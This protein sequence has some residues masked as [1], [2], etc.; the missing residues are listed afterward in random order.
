MGPPPHEIGRPG[1]IYVDNSSE[2]LAIYGRDKVRWVIWPGPG[3][4]FRHP[5]LEDRYLWCSEDRIAWYSGKFVVDDAKTRSGQTTVEMI[6]QALTNEFE[7]HGVSDTEE[8]RENRRQRTKAEKVRDEASQSGKR[9]SSDRKASDD[10]ERLK[11]QKVE[12]NGGH[13]VEETSCRHVEGEGEMETHGSDTSECPSEGTDDEVRQR[14]LEKEA[15]IVN[16][17]RAWW[18]DAVAQMCGRCPLVEARAST[19]DNE[20]RLLEAT[21]RVLEERCAKEER[22]RRRLAE[23]CDN[24]A[25]RRDGDNEKVAADNQSLECLHQTSREEVETLGQNI[26]ALKRKVSDD[27]KQHLDLQEKNMRQ[28]QQIALLLGENEKM[29]SGQE[30][31]SRNAEMSV[32]PVTQTSKMPKIVLDCLPGHMGQTLATHLDS[33]ESYNDK[34]F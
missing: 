15:A 13:N 14:N 31:A 17:Q 11:R 8:E 23:L 25:E 7:G 9:T 28:E 30:R 22:E 5:T 32:T 12:H 21:I 34:Y 29:K 10:S 33:R 26:A 24:M 16:E 20:K 3:L 1:D 19:L 6:Q 27:L 2:S 18:L 4:F